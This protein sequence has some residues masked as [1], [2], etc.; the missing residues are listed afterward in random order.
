VKAG[1]QTELTLEIKGEKFTGFEGEL[2]EK[3]GIDKIA[4]EARSSYKEIRF[5]EKSADSHDG[6][7]VDSSECEPGLE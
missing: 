1:A 7:S 4:K 5:H 2:E 3:S 6:H